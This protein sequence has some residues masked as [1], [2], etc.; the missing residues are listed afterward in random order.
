[1]TMLPCFSPLCC[2]WC[3]ILLSPMVH[4]GLVTWRPN[5]RRGKENMNPPQGSPLQGVPYRSKA[6]A[7]RGV[8]TENSFWNEVPLFYC[9]TLDPITV[10]DRLSILGHGVHSIEDR[11]CHDLTNVSCAQRNNTS[12][13]L[14]SCEI[15]PGKYSHRVPHYAFFPYP[16]LSL[17]RFCVFAPRLA[18][19]GSGPQTETPLWRLGW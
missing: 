19:P 14:L 11:F 13:S 18:T 9:S 7:G 16:P 10:I 4:D 5:R 12:A 15:Y 1:M 8:G 2:T 6:S 17:L 3:E